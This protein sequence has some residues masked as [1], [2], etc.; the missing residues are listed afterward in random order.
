[1]LNTPTYHHQY[2]DLKYYYSIHVN[3]QK[4]MWEEPINYD[5]FIK[6]AKKMS[7]HDAIYNPRTKPKTTWES[8][9]PIQDY[10]RRQEKLR[11][12]QI[13][14]IDLDELAKVEAKYETQDK[15]TF[16]NRF[17]SFFTN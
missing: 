8:K 10:I 6:R 9:T 3:R 11:E 7:L 15:P 4:A 16:I 2:W 17:I 14:I 1:M 5:S 12:E 13:P